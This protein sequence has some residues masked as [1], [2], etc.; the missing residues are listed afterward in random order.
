MNKKLAGIKAVD[1][2]DYKALY[3]ELIMEVGSSWPGE[4]R[5]ET[6]RRYIREHETPC[7]GCRGDSDEHICH[8]QVAAN[9]QE[10]D[11]HE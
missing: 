1:T 7:A 3:Y 6:A 5:H 9:H 4:S 11:N 10:P 8:L 2:N